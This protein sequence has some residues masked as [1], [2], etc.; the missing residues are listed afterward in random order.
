MSELELT[1]QQVQHFRTFGFLV[2]RGLLDAD[3][4]AR[5]TAEV[6]ESLRAAY[7]PG[8]G[9]DGSDYLPLTADRTPFSQS[10]IAD[11]P[12]LFQGSTELLGSATVPAAPEAVC[13]GH[14]FG[15][16]TDIGPDVA[17]V[18]FLAHLQPR[19]AATGALRVVP[20]SHEPSFAR[21]VQAY[22]GHD[23]GNQGF[24]GW[25]LP[26]TVLETEPGDVLAFDVHLLHSSAGGERRLAWR[27][28]YLEWPGMGAPDRM[29]TVR[30]L[31]TDAADYTDHGFDTAA[32][33]VWQEW[34]EGAD[35]RPSRQVAV[36]RLRLLGVVGE[37]G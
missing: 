30:D 14:N 27:T 2:L 12:R 4:A 11:D 15:W 13:F 33:P 28:E 23:P 29:R 36:E 22:L 18:T 8:L 25:P 9:D 21:R 6:S 16:H 35:S 5:L 19:T 37:G 20:G 7:G 24:E 26:A 3:E 10:L 32:W 17:G 1:H 31:I 34:A